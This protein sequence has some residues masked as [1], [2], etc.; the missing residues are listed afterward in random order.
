MTPTTSFCCCQKL[1]AVLI[2]DQECKFPNKYFETMSSSTS[3]HHTWLQCRMHN[4]HAQ[5]E[6]AVEAQQQAQEQ[7]H[8]QSK[9]R[10]KLEAGF[11][12]VSSGCIPGLCL[13][14]TFTTPQKCSSMRIWSRVWYSWLWQ[15]CVVCFWGVYSNSCAKQGCVCCWCN[16]VQEAC[17]Y[18]L[19]H[20]GSYMDE[21]THTMQPPYWVC[22][23]FL[24]VQH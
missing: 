16:N 11:S 8:E 20:V 17:T 14:M 12:Q 15:A 5:R 1:H 6:Q 24:H 4:L 10:A 19:S 21:W 2:S 22:A 3:L 9:R 18:D 7:R 13:C 23:D